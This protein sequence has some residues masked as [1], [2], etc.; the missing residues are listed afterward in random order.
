MKAEGIAVDRLTLQKDPTGQQSQ[1]D[2]QPAEKGDQPLQRMEKGG[3]NGET[4]RHKKDLFRFY[5]PL[6]RMG[7]FDG[8]MRGKEIRER[9][10][11]DFGWSA[12]KRALF[13]LYP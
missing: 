13:T 8:F 9:Y 2:A 10:F 5:F 11:M 3:M 6:E 7:G 12:V 4:V 1:K